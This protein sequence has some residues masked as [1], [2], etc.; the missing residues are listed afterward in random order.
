MK[1]KTTLPYN[2]LFRNIW[3]CP[4]SYKPAI[5]YLHVKDILSARTQKKVDE[6]SFTVS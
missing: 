3:L 4:K 6:L 2:Y 1:K 5:G